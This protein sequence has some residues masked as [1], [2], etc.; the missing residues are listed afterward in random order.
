MDKLRVK[1]MLEMQMLRQGD[2]GGA[3]KKM[4][5]LHKEHDED[6]VDEDANYEMEREIAQITHLVKILR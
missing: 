1:I 3:G 5:E 6:D 4:A 2:D